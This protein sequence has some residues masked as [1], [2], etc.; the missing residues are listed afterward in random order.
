MSFNL[1]EYKREWQKKRRLTWKCDVKDVKVIDPEL[2]N[3]YYISKYEFRTNHKAY[4]ELGLTVFVDGIQVL[5]YKE[6][7]IK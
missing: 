6:V 3:P 7:V 1:T 5:P 4:V 2:A